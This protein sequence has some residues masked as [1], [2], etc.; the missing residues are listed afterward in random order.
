M[1]VVVHILQKFPIAYFAI[2]ASHVLTRSEKLVACHAVA[3][4]EVL[5][6]FPSFLANYYDK[7]R[8]C[9]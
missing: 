9:K 2:L 6:F 4:N 7:Q 5:L 1:L 3:F 8:D